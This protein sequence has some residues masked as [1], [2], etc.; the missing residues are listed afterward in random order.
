MYIFDYDIYFNKT[1]DIIYKKINI[2]KF[3]KNDIIKISKDISNL[4]TPYSNKND[5]IF[6]ITKILLLSYLVIVS[7]INDDIRDVKTI[8]IKNNIIGSEYLGQLLSLIKTYNTILDVLNIEN[9]NKLRE[10]YNSNIQYKLA[11]DILNN[12]GY[13]N[14]SLNLKTKDKELN[15][16]N[17][18]KLLIVL[19]FYKKFF[20]KKIFNLLFSFSDKKQY[21]EIIQ[22]KLKLLDY[23]NIESILN[24]K[25]IN[26]GLTKQIFD[27]Y[28]KLEITENIS[29][30]INKKVNNLFNSKLVIPIVDDFLRYHKTTE[31]YQK[32]T[33]QFNKFGDKKKDQSKLKF[34][35]SRLDNIINMY[36]NKIQNN[37]KLLSEIKKYFYK[38]LSHKNAIIYNEI[39]ELDIIYKLNLMN[40][41]ALI[42]N[43]LYQELKNI[44]KY[45][46]I[47]F[48]HLK[49]FGFKYLHNKQLTVARSSI[50]NNNIN[51]NIKID[52]RTINN[53]SDVNIIGIIILDNKSK[54]S[55]VRKKNISNIH[56]IND[57]GYEACK[58]ILENKIN[59]N[60]NTN[61]YWIFNGNDKIEVDSYEISNN[62]NNI[63]NIKDKLILSKLYDLSIEYTYNFII[64]K[65]NIYTT[66]D[67]FYSNYINHYYQNNLIK[68]KNNN[69][70]I[71]LIN[72]KINDLIPI[73]KNYT[74]KNDDMIFGI[75]G[76]VKKLP[77]VKQ[78]NKD[79]SKYIIV[80]Y[81]DTSQLT[82][83]EEELELFECQH[84]IDWNNTKRM[85]NKDP[86]KYNE[87][88][89]N[90]VNKYVTSDSS[91]HYKQQFICKSCNQILEVEYII[92]DVFDS[93]TTGFNIQIE[94]HKNLNEIKEYAKYSYLIKNIDK[95]VERIARINNFTIYIGNEK[96][97]KI[98][99]Q[100]IIKQVID[101]I[102]IHDKTLRSKN[103]NKREREI[104]ALQNYGVI[105]R[106]TNFFIFPLSDDI[107]KFSSNETDKFKK[108][109]INNIIS[110]I[111]FFMI[112][113]MNESQVLLLEFDKKCNYV[114]FDKIY[115]SY[116][117]DLKV[118]TDFSQNKYNLL[119]NE[120]FCYILYHISCMI[121]KFNIW[122]IS[123]E[124]KN[125]KSNIFTQYSIIH[126]VI[127]L[128][129]NLM[130][131]TLNK[132]R[133]YLYD[134]ILSK[135]IN[136]LKILKNSNVLLEIKESQGKILTI[137]ENTNKI[138][139][140]KKKFESFRLNGEDI[141]KKR[142]FIDQKRNYLYY[143]MNKFLKP[144]RSINNEKLTT[145][146]TKLKD[147]S[148]IRYAQIYND[149]GIK[150]F[151]ISLE[152]AK[153]LGKEYY[154]NMINNIKPYEIKS[155][156]NNKINKIEKRFDN[157]KINSNFN[158]FLS[159]IS[160][161]SS[162][163]KYKNITYHLYK[164]YIE[165]NHDFLGNEV[166]TSSFLNVD[167]KIINIY[168]DKELNT[169][170]YEIFDQSNKIK[171][172]FGYYSLQYLGYKKGSNFIDM[173]I[174]N[175][176]FKYIPSIKEM[177]ETIGFKRNYYNFKS[178]NQ[179]NNEILKSVVNLKNYIK[180]FILFFNQIKYKHKNID[181]I[182]I[183]NYMQRIEDIKL[184]KFKHTAFQDA[185]I[186]NK[187]IKVKISKIDKIQN[188][189]KYKLINS[190]DE[191][192]KLLDYLISELL[193]IIDINE[194][195]YLK[196]NIVNLIVNILIFNYYDNYEQIYEFEILRYTNVINNELL[197][198]IKEESS[199]GDINL[200]N[201]NEEQKN[202][203]NNQINDLN[204]RDDARDITN[205]EDDVFSDEDDENNIYTDGLD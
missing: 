168:E 87:S 133:N 185:N 167:N 15:K 139:I 63:Q 140:S 99:R 22:P 29:N 66:L 141:V 94:T 44:R 52:T 42:G 51:K 171:L 103:M 151:K 60:N 148:K 135:Y 25:E 88:I 134:V 118:I 202:E 19:S 197:K 50:F 160:K 53:D 112:L 33:T 198:E 97:N 84:V 186:I 164:S 154:K 68:I 117:K 176:Y 190:C 184:S 92:S 16:H 65:L 85:K 127:D 93:N 101:I 34:I 162:T 147:L 180:Y 73:D 38:P 123:Q 189:D 122:Y 173:R 14:V 110:Y 79:T 55:K 136:K 107:F 172:I 78:N 130:E 200:N 161:I 138:V 86:N 35:T 181:N 18:I 188:I 12:Y 9:K 157:I 125:I 203:L 43:S 45:S 61:Y 166:K 156:K 36:S 89:Y 111:I 74:D 75:L 72:N 170:I 182:I 7:L 82:N 153:N 5:E 46:Y 57:N 100:D 124:N 37:Y 192:K 6:E 77:V 56:D 59:N 3:N 165:F 49:K 201:L 90:F 137:N 48:R 193:F 26:D 21:I 194:S 129:N 126:T 175:I 158:K 120:V 109:K 70:Y 13:T 144:K 54:L 169:K 17:L 39:E 67:L 98:R 64:K 163:F 191:Y 108:I 2:N 150:K 119:N 132:K 146:N 199:I 121:S 204:E 149:N 96:I 40:K 1:L 24:Y 105:G 8:I 91:N 62:N 102:T 10:L 95:I 31:K 20:R 104:K 183:K 28:E 11:I 4:F 179:I 47:N 113:D 131:V 32:I 155:L 196:L 106:Y 27:Y 114:I 116:F 30:D 195:K 81:D 159:E 76:K 115:K 205:E 128:I 142:D 143:Y 174:T 83:N 69:T 178:S 41:S 23:N 177:I 145:L 58:K 152:K 71:Q 187:F 80:P